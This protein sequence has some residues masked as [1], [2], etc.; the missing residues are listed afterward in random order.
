M[1]TNEERRV[2]AVVTWQG[3]LLGEVGPFPVDSPHWA[4]AACV[5]D[6]LT[7]RIGVPAVVLRLLSVDGGE[8]GRGGLVRYHVEALE[9]PAA[10]LE[11]APVDGELADHPLRLPWATADGLRAALDWAGAEL[12]ALGRPALGPAEQVKTW[13]LSGLFRIPTADGP[14][15]LK[16]TP[17]FGVDEARAIAL[18]ATADPA[19]VPGVLAADDHRVLLEQVPGVDCW[20]V[21]EDAMLDAVENLAR[22]QAALAGRRDPALSDRTPAALAGAFGE[23]LASGKVTDLSAEELAA[24][25]ALTGQLPG[26]ADALAACGLPES[27]VH[28]DYHP[29]NWRHRDGVTVAIDFSDA[30]FGH[31]AFDG[32][33]ARP[34]L[35][36]E[37][38][39]EARGRWVAAWRELAPGSDPERALELAAPLMH[40][41]YAIR[42]QEFLDGIEPSERIYHEGD[43]AGEIRRALEAVAG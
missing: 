15:W 10:E 12:A 38:W 26:I 37:R 11:P 40:V 29:G 13:N 28:G 34:F 33:R 19:L 4:E 14:V 7:D 30:F 17:P 2:T 5:V 43:P 36:P 35:S 16:T 27:P 39:A 18:F 3:E 20:G 6:G 22:A 23:L 41:Y 8:G 32:L 21:P 31:P 9:R 42:Y 24:A 25:H 1:Q